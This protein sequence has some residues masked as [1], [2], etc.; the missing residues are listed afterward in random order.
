MVGLEVY[1]A[2]GGGGKER[3]EGEGEGCPTACTRL[4]FSC[5]SSPISKKKLKLPAKTNADEPQ[6]L[7]ALFSE[8]GVSFTEFI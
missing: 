4:R 5:R 6:S 7:Q 3:L 1:I 8:L 2:E